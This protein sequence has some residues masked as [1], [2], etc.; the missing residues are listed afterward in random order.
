MG[1]DVSKNIVDISTKILTNVAITSTNECQVVIDSLEEIT[2]IN[3]SG[4]NISGVNFTDTIGVNQ[5]CVS[6]ASTQNQVSANVKNVANQ[7]AKTID[8][9][10]EIPRGTRES[11]NV[12]KVMNELATNIT[13]TFNQKC[14]TNLNSDIVVKI[15]ASNDVVFFNDNFQVNIDDTQ[16][17]IEQNIDKTNITNQLSNQISQTASTEV[18]SILGA[19]IFI[20]III[21]VIGGGLILGGEKALTN[22]KLWL[23]LLLALAFYFVMAYFVGLWPFDKKKKSKHDNRTN[24]EFQ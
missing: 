7:I 2:I 9:A 3:S 18:K 5:S 12:A 8:Q 10:F 21:L 13:E 19:L 20:V 6:K 1:G 14:N 17:C 24:E 11:E 22:W 16:S 15:I 23:V 4:V